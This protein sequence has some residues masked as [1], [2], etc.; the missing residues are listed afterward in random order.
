MTFTRFMTA[1]LAAVAASATDKTYKGTY[2]A[3]LKIAATSAL[4]DDLDT[5][6]AGDTPEDD[7]TCE[8]AWMDAHICKAIGDAHTTGTD[9]IFDDCTS[10]TDATQGSFAISNKALSGGNYSATITLVLNDAT[11]MGAGAKISAAKTALDAMVKGVTT[12]G[13]AGNADFF[14]ALN[15][16]ITG[17]ALN[18]GL[19]ATGTPL[20]VP[21]GEGSGA[22]NGTVK[23]EVSDDAG[24]LH[25]WR[26]YQA[27]F[28]QT[29][30]FTMDWTTE[31]ASCDDTTKIA[32]TACDATR[33]SMGEWLCNVFTDGSSFTKQ[34]SSTT[35][36]EWD[37][38]GRNTAKDEQGIAV[39]SITVTAGRRLEED[40]LENGNKRKLAAAASEAS[41]SHHSYY[42]TA[43][44]AKTGAEAMD[45]AIT[46]LFTTN[47]DATKTALINQDNELTAVESFSAAK[48]SHG[49]N[50][51]K[52]AF[53]VAGIASTVL[54][55]VMANL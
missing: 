47:L 8:M 1:A 13:T 3:T 48:A 24:A 36:D 31:N 30:K 44:A 20:L 26:A 10:A 9:K 11:L 22:A 21:A 35:S 51:E 38:N 23:V 37:C 43:D 7:G 50:A 34:N 15:T 39:S 14:T 53:R 5:A 52:A 29:V 33:Q 32:T 18:K 55:L 40:F 19:V 12:D 25:G 41:Y 46:A 45:T 17:D 16:A 4:C 42:D 28:S 54:F 6:T 2:T 49:A 27:N